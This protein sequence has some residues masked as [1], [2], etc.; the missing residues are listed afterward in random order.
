VQVKTLIAL[1]KKKKIC[2]SLR[3]SASKN[4]LA[5]LRIKS[6][7]NGGDQNWSP[8]FSFNH[9]RAKVSRITLAGLLEAYQHQVLCTFSGSR[10]VDLF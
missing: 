7:E 6:N 4:A 10:N 5:L 8:P 2:V 9:Q 1:I 3:E